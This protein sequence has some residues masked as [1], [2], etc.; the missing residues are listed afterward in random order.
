M[1]G[2]YIGTFLSVVDS[3][4]LDSVLTLHCP[5]RTGSLFHFLLHSYMYS[6]HNSIH[7]TVTIVISG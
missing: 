3:A 7:G 1:G 2:G 5:L 6:T 4:G